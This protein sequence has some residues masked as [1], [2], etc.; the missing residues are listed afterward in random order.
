MDIVSLKKKER[1]E[2]VVRNLETFSTNVFSQR[3]RNTRIPVGEVNN[4]LSFQK[5]EKKQEEALGNDGQED[6]P[7]TSVCP[8]SWRQRRRN[9]SFQCCVQK[10]GNG[11][12][13]R[14]PPQPLA[15]PV[16]GGDGEMQS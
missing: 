6:A 12:N 3:C 11:E 7:V 14:P 16:E 1:E 8:P 15:T 2:T 10:A 5:A 13:I 9:K 4:D